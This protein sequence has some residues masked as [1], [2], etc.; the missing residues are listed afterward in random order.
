[1]L[2]LIT[3]K[4]IQRS[5]EKTYK[6]SIRISLPSNKQRLSMF[7]IRKYLMHDPNDNAEIG[8]IVTMV[9][10]KKSKNISLQRICI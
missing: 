9:R 1:M 2:K 6:V 7:Q 8:K 10:K 5:S 4:V 3:G